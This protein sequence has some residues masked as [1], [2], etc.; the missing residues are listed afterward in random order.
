MGKEILIVDD[1]VDI[2]LLISGILKDEGYTTRL[3]GNSSEALLSFENSPP[4]A[5]AIFDIWLQGSDHDGMHLLDAFHKRYPN[6]PVLM[7]SGHGNIETAVSSIKKG[8]YDF[9]E[10]PF[11]SDRLILLVQRALEAARLR[12]ENEELKLRASPITELVGSS[13]SINNVR[14]AIERVAPTGSRVLISGP[15]GSGKEVVARLIHQ[16][17]RRSSGPFI[18]V[19]AAILTP[20]SLERE[21]FGEEEYVEGTN[22]VN[23]KKIG[24]LEQAHGGTLFIDGV[25]DMP[26]ET[27]GKIVR[28]LQDQTFER[29]GGS[30]KVEVDARVIASSILD[31]E[32]EITK[33]NFREDLF[34]RLNVVPLKIPALNERREDIPD[35]AKFFMAI[36]SSTSGLPSRDLTSDALMALQASEWPGNV[37]QL[38]NVIEWLL[39]MAPGS[40]NDPITADVLPP[41]LTGGSTT[42]STLERDGEIM[43]LPLRDARDVFEREYLTVQI[44]R[45]G[46]NISRT[47]EFVG[48]E[49]TALHRKLKTLGIV[50]NTKRRDSIAS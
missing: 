39:I 21:L 25:T 9:I 26:M 10:K 4:P 28:V 27:Q 6:L 31:I 33:G 43:S 20:N 22:T 12:R 49:R 16:N 1:E 34:Y 50:D 23:L 48:M 30:K 35:L 8:A 46:G 45:F 18:T 40:K 15:S 17:S 14:G 11:K 19:N 7:I 2:R 13:S 3:A 24:L 5:L 42:F 38:R 41:E 29:V 36:A 32:T 37:R 44:D 47:S